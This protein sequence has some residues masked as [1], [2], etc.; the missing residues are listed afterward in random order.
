MPTS[1]HP[2]EPQSRLDREISEILEEARKRPISFQDRVAQKRTAAQVQKESAVARARSTGAG[3][4]K[5]AWS[6]VVR[7]PLVAALI[8]ALI[9]VWLAPDYQVVATL[10]GLVAAALIFMPFVLKRPDEHITYQKKWRGRPI[11]SPR[12]QGTGMEGT[13]RSWIDSARSRFGR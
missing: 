5:T 10:L 8:V 12:A 13:V 1:N 3:P 11:E 4:L 7:L 9:A 2:E 6:W